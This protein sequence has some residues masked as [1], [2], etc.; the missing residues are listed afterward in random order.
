MFTTFVMHIHEM[1]YSKEIS[2]KRGKGDRSTIL[3]D[4][5]QFGRGP[6][7][8]CCDERWDEHT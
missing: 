5:A 2:K 1:F 7:Q 3:P 8:E 4:C 6:S